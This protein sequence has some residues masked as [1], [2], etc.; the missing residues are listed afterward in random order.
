[1]GHI[2]SGRAGVA[3]GIAMLA[4]VGFL[5]LAPGPS[6]GIVP[7]GASFM[8]TT[9]IEVTLSS[10][11]SRA[12]ALDIINGSSKPVTMRLALEEQALPSGAMAYPITPEPDKSGTIAATKRS[13][14]AHKLWRPTIKLSASQSSGS[15]TAVLI[16][17]ASDGTFDRRTLSV[18][19]QTPAA[20]S[21][22]PTTP[23]DEL[24]ATTLTEPLP[25]ITLQVTRSAWPWDDDHP[26]TAATLALDLSVAAKLVPGA[27]ISDDGQI[28][29][30][31]VNV[32]TGTITFVG[33]QPGAYKGSLA[34]RADPANKD[35]KTPQALTDVTL[36]VRDEIGA[37][38]LLL[39][40]GLGAAIVLEW[41]AT[42]VLPKRGLDRQLA[43]LQVR[44]ETKH[45]EQVTWIKGRADWPGPE[46]RAPRITGLPD[47]TGNPYL[48]DAT[49]K[50]RSDFDRLASF[51]ERKDR[52]GGNGSEFGK[53]LAAADKYE[54]LLMAQRALALGWPA[55]VAALP[56]G[57]N[58][59][60]AA[61]G[62][63]DREV[64]AAL[65]NG[66][67]HTTDEIDQ[68]LKAA[69]D[70]NA[71]VG[72]I[73]N[74]AGFLASIEALNPTDAADTRA[75]ADLW[76][77]VA[78]MTDV[79]GQAP[80]ALKSARD[81]Y[82]K[83]VEAKR[84]LDVPVGLQV[85]QFLTA[86]EGETFAPIDVIRQLVGPVIQRAP[87]RTVLED[88]VAASESASLTQLLINIGFAVIVSTFAIASG[89]STQYFGKSTFGSVG[90]YLSMFLWGLG[91]VSAAQLVR[92][93]PTVASIVTDLG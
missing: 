60:L 29:T 82:T 68:A 78:G 17:I 72:T 24:N 13:V 3:L 23:P 25:T 61:H 52:W 76:R 89:L 18:S 33:K 42:D 59:T 34:R 66:V 1:M 46:E 63:I 35:E 67:L 71:A 8:I 45:Q 86:Q 28:A 27:L 20:V 6:E 79:E 74:L 69:D 77:D 2:V 43:A 62:E 70:A 36:D 39:L 56:E 83:V 64:R 38:L 15:F 11:E 88:L 22:G 32:K 7:R 16:V 51:E 5:F 12:I 9:P 54:S 14:G 93:L 87:A 48:V 80:A 41:L 50:A 21:A 31:T 30:M 81:L 37:A 73:T 44:A 58:R 84:D 55:F 40:A 4:G 90:D 10:G 85:M 49:A 47:E 65:R 92:H 26:A 57:Q 19:V 91:T 75:L 53:I